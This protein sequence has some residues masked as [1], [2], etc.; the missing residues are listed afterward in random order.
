[1]TDN[2]IGLPESKDDAKAA[3]D[4]LKRNLPAILENAKIVAEIKRANYLAYIEQGF[5][6]HQALELIKVPTM[7]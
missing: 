3:I 6:E 5:S 7:L 4:Q 2:I 1:M